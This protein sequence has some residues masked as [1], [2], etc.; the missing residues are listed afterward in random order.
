MPPAAGGWS[1][2][3]APPAEFMPKT[4]PAIRARATAMRV[5]APHFPCHLVC[6]MMASFPDLEIKA[7]YP[8][9]CT[10]QDHKINCYDRRY[11]QRCQP[12]RLMHR[13]AESDQ[14]SAAP[15]RAAPGVPIANENRLVEPDR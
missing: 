12:V 5:G 15:A 1:P 3:L 7:T 13:P 4:K 10:V 11:L 8:D 6:R 2:A 14:L 9:A